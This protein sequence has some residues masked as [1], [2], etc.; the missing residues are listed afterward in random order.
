[1]VHIVKPY[2]ITKNL[3]EAYNKTM[4][5]IPDGDW[6]CICD[7]DTMFL[8]PDCGEIL[9]TYAEMF[10]DY[11]LL[12]C[13]TNRIHP[14]AFKQIYGGQVSEDDSIRNH[15]RIAQQA[16]DNLYQVS[17]ITHEVSGFLML[18]SKKTWNK[19][20]FKETGR[21]LGVDNTFCWNLLENKEKIGVMLGLY[22]W[23]SYRLHDIKDKSHLK[24][25]S[26]YG[27]IR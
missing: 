27:N 24:N 16:K 14:L 5:M 21:C 10:P 22:V 9:N 17:D 2:S 1:M 15:Q 26:V 6:A 12:T 13:L 19:V 18:I 3:G 11:G 20:K 8:T 7:Y 4:Q 23:H 25:D